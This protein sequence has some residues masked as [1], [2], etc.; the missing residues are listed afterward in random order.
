MFCLLLC[1][2]LKKSKHASNSWLVMEVSYR[3]LHN[4]FRAPSLDFCYVCIP[5][6]LCIGVV[7]MKFIQQKQK[8][9]KLETTK[10]VW[11]RENIQSIVHSSTWLKNHSFEWCLS[12][13]LATIFAVH[14]D[15][16]LLYRKIF[17][18]RPS[19]AKALSVGREKDKTY[20]CKTTHHGSIKC[21]MNDISKLPLVI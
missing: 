9:E 6:Y 12:S 20:N 10:Q 18:M 17:D 15:L 14:I 7:A 4:I 3:L 2:R 16:V 1:N 19:A 13:L 21:R 8:S 5:F 11:R